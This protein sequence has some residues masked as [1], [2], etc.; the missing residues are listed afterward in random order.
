MPV[1]QLKIEEMKQNGAA[2]EEVKVALCSLEWLLAGIQALHQPNRCSGND[3]IAHIGNQ[4]GYEHLWSC[5]GNSFRGTA[6][7]KS[8]QQEATQ[9]RRGEQRRRP[10]ELREHGAHKQ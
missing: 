4:P 1:H 5:A 7:S 2:V 8:D 3:C 10:A 9:D 6:C